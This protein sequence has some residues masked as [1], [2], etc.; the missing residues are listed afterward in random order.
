MKE[1]PAQTYYSFQAFP[2]VFELVQS[3]SELD[4]ANAKWFE[5]ARWKISKVLL[6]HD[7]QIDTCLVKMWRTVGHSH[8]KF[9]MNCH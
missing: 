6:D 2:L 4:H 3:H 9:Q 5:M 7:Q 1:P 8:E